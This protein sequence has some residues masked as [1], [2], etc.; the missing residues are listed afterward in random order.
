MSAKKEN[1]FKNIYPNTPDMGH[2]TFAFDHI[3]TK[4]KADLSILKN[5]G[6]MADFHANGILSVMFKFVAPPNKL[7]N[8]VS[9]KT[10]D[11]EPTPNKQHG[12]G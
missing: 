6:I 5:A 7:V 11:Q 10:P 2:D 9:R 3:A 4:V 8:S 1:N 12:R